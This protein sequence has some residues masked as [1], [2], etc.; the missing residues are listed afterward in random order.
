MSEFFVFAK[1]HIWNT[2][3][4]ICGS[5]SWI[6]KPQCC[7]LVSTRHQE[8]QVSLNKVFDRQTSG[9][10]GSKALWSDFWIDPKRRHWHVFESRLFFAWVLSLKRVFNNWKSDKAIIWSSPPLYNKK[11]ARPCLIVRCI[12]HQALHKFC[13]PG[14]KLQED[15]GILGFGLSFGFGLGQI[16]YIYI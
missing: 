3:I 6:M 10:I 15:L 11:D 5:Y 16:L 8:R 9:K 13:N 7:L 14:T 1:C 12:S 4:S 2:L